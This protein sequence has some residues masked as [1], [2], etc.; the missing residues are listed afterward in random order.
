MEEA[1]K[2]ESVAIDK[3]IGHRA[4]PN[5]MSGAS[6]KKLVGH[7]ERTGNYEPVIVRPH[8]DRSGCFEIIN[9]HHR[10]EAL[11]QLGRERCDC[12]VWQVD[13]TEV[14]LLIAT[15]N[16][17]CGSDELDKKSE[18]IKSLSKR[19]STKE[20]V[21]KLVE[22]RKS[23][24]RLKELSRPVPVPGGLNLRQKALLN[25]L[26]FFLTDEQ[27]RIVDTALSKATQPHRV[28]MGTALGQENKV[29][30]ATA[31]GQT[32][33]QKRAEAIVKIAETFLRVNT[34]ERSDY[35]G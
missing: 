30:H 8:P 27:K 4:N 35:E 19:F 26:M 5:R 23:I 34:E 1:K 17:L 20:L 7:I 15:L 3:L 24:E 13:D 22:S 18:L 11:K 9:G 12:V 29:A 14:L 2:I 16:R 6:F 31:G 28:R 32:A 10:V 33:A 21:G 25:P